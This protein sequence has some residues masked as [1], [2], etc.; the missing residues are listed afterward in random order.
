LNQGY[1]AQAQSRELNKLYNTWC[2][3]Q[4]KG[5]QKEYKA[6]LL[7]LRATGTNVMAAATS[8][9]QHSKRAID[10]SRIPVAGFRD[11]LGMRDS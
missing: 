10:L 3:C 6:Y 5:V 2:D 1:Q 4:S 11:R 8:I 7:N 9:Q